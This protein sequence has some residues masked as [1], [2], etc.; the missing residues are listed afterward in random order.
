MPARKKQTTRAQSCLHERLI[1]PPADHHRRTWAPG[2]GRNE[3]TYSV[4]YGDNKRRWTTGEGEPRLK[5]SGCLVLA[6]RDS[7]FLSFFLL[8]ESTGSA[9]RFGRA[10]HWRMGSSNHTAVK[11][12]RSGVLCRLCM[13]Y[14]WLTRLPRPHQIQKAHL[15]ER[16]SNRLSC[17]PPPRSCFQRP[18]SEVASHLCLAVHIVGLKTGA[19][20]AS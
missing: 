1:L 16:G 17:V 19:A 13:A 7:F 10:G 9:S 3:C 6:L 15:M 5:F 14:N 18:F 11:R 4:F 2:Y 20:V 8:L 12:R